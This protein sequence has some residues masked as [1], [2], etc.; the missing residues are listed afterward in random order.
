[1]QPTYARRR[2][3]KIANLTDAVRALIA[4]GTIHEFD[5]EW[6]GGLPADRQLDAAER[7]VRTPIV[8]HRSG[9]DQCR[10][11]INTGRQR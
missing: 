4:A 11:T 3:E 6:I 9:Q 1:M 5:G 10:S 2:R 8:C 7:I